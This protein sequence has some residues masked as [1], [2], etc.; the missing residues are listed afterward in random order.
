M[1]TLDRYIARQFLIN[2]GALAIMLGAFV[3]MVDV[4]LNADEY[5]RRADETSGG[6]AGLRRALV[7]VLL[8]WDLW[9]PRLLQLLNFTSGLILVGAMGF[10]FA[11]LV[12]HRELVAM[13]AGGV[14]LFRAARPV[15][16][17]SVLL[18]GAQ[19]A[20]QELVLPHLSPLL[21]RSIKDAG[22]REF[23]RYQVPL[24]SDKQ[25][26][27]LT[28]REFDP[29]TSTLRGLYVLERDA[30]GRAIRRI[31]ADTAVWD[32]RAGLWRLTNGIGRSMRLAELSPT[33]PR[34]RSGEVVT[35]VPTSVDPTVL[36]ANQY[37][38]Y[39]QTLSWGQLI[40]GIR[41]PNLPRSM[42]DDLSRIAWGRASTLV[43]IILSMV[44]CLPY[45]LTRE[46]KNMVTQSL[47][48]APVAIGTLVGT[49]LGASA[50][51]PTDLLPP[52]IAAFVPVLAM[53]PIAI[54]QGTSIRT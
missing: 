32:Q 11:Q 33:D 17:V 1:N 46:P 40:E 37:R 50:P 54:A 44:I 30:E 22:K 34:A 35:T 18:L 53:L 3:V 7:T 31:T 49:V 27:V 51:I 16:V 36:L 38:F 15:M 47:K 39:S 42:R 29:N 45:F 23:D 20:N 48:A 43:G 9:W 4:S 41:L 21:S 12:R 19:V 2:V 25:G 14:S 13:M 28:A 52:M 26:R 10:T 5:L 6:A 8:V 24:V